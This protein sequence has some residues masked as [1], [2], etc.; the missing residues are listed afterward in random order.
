VGYR[1]IEVSEDQEVLKMEVWEGNQSI[2]II[3]FYNPCEKLCKNV[4]EKIRGNTNQK[5]VWCGDF[6]AHNTL[7]GSVK[8]DYNGLI[9]EEMLEWGRLVC[10]NNGNM[11]RIDVSNGRNSVLDITL[12][13]ENLAQKCEWTVNKFSG[14]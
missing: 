1:N 13:S 2:K 7:W 6:N 4:M 14:K 8:T 5:V 9:V 12:V 3:N 11:T 10:I